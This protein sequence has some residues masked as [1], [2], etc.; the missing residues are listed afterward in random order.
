MKDCVF[1]QIVSGEKS[2]EIVYQD[3]QVLAFN[4]LHPKTRVH[5]LVIPKK[6]IASISEMKEEDETLIGH[7][8]F[9]AQKIAH[10]KGLE[11][12]H[13]IFNVGSQG[14]Q[15]IFHIHLHLISAE[16]ELTF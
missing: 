10:G 1:C 3:D 11:G 16:K 7:L 14:G 9:V 13:L 6:H 12:Y 5:I 2:A 8:I 15:K 4:D